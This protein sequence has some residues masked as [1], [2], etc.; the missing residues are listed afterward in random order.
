MLIDCINYAMGPKEYANARDEE[1]NLP[2]AAYAIRDNEEFNERV[3]VA[4][5]F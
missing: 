3:T 5:W 2:S 4:S 1:D